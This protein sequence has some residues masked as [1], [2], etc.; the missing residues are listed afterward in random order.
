[1]EEPRLRGFSDFEMKCFEGRERNSK[2]IRKFK[3]NQI[4]RITGMRAG[5][6]GLMWATQGN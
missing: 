4:D 1:M 6:K 3:G 2:G 5:M